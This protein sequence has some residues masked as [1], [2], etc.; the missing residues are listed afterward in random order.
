MR[1][2]GGKSKQMEGFTNN[3]GCENLTSFIFNNWDFVNDEKLG[4]E[5]RITV[6]KMGKRILDTKL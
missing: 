1:R 4:A 2:E 5:C 6:K 3:S